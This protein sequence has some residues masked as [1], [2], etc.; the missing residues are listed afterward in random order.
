MMMVFGILLIMSFSR[1]TVPQMAWEITAFVPLL[2]RLMGLFGLPHA[3]EL[4]FYEMEIS[5]PS[6]QIT[7]F[8][9]TEFG[10]SNLIRKEPPGL[11]PDLVWFVFFR[12]IFRFSMSKRD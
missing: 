7:G 5:E 3:A 2:K 6:Q 4:P 12:E 11:E 1:N 10:I 8:L 9:I